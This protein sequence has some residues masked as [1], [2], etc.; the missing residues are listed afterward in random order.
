MHNIPVVL[1]LRLA[2]DRGDTHKAQDLIDRYDLVV[3]VTDAVEVVDIP[4]TQIEFYELQIAQLIARQHE[5]HYFVQKFMVEGSLRRT[6]GFVGLDKARCVERFKALKTAV[7]EAYKRRYFAHKIKKGAAASEAY[8]SGFMEAVLDRCRS[9]VRS[10]DFYRSVF[11]QVKL[12]DILERGRRS[13]RDQQARSV[14]LDDGLVA[15][16]KTLNLTYAK[17]IRSGEEFQVDCASA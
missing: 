4:V 6:L 5:V 12:R 15:D 16:P 11:D 2:V 13:L 14:G 3:H 10:E 9:C 8:R 7:D 17:S 1:K